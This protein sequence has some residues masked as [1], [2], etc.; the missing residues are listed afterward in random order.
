MNGKVL[1]SKFLG[2]HTWLEN[3]SLYSWKKGFQVLDKSLHT[4]ALHCPN[5]GGNSF[6][7]KENLKLTDPYSSP[8]SFIP[9]YR[10]ESTPRMLISPTARLINSRMPRV[11]RVNAISITNI[12]LRGSWSGNMNWRPAL[13]A[14]HEWPDKNHHLQQEWNYREDT[15]SLWTSSFPYIKWGK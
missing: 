14:F 12:K 8:L 5:I 6:W 7:W 13:G 1:W 11:K 9:K 4:F 2:N 15:E 3:T 10:P